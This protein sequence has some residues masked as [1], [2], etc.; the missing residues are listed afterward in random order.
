MSYWVTIMEEK[1]QTSPEPSSKFNSLKIKDDNY[2]TKIEALNVFATI[3]VKDYLEIAKRIK[4]NNDLQRKRVGSSS[5]VYGLLKEDLRNGCLIPSIVLALDNDNKEEFV[6]KGVEYNVIEN[7][8]KTYANELK[9]LDGL[10]RTNILLDLE[11]DLSVSNGKSPEQIASDKILLEAFYGRELRVEIYL[12]VSRFGILYRMLTLNTGQTPMTLRHQIEIL[13]SDYYDKENGGVTLIRDAFESNKPLKLG[14]YRFSD[15]VEGVTSF[16]D[17][18]ELPLDRYDLL[19]YIKSVKKLSSEDNKV[20]IFNA[21]KN[22]YNQLLQSIIEK[23][24]NW[25]FDYDAL[26]E[27][28]LE[29]FPVL[30]TSDDNS[31]KSRVSPFGKTAQEIFIKSQVYT[32]LG[33]A[34]SNLKNKGTIK[35]LDDLDQEFS[36]IKFE[37]APKDAFDILVVRMEQIRKD[38]KKIG[39]S[40]RTFFKHFFNSLLNKNDDD[41]YLM[42]EKAID[43]A[44][45]KTN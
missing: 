32:G 20:D 16:I 21:F 34:L 13:Y 38:S 30:S 23:S 40:Q 10:Q 44:F 7:G 2:D 14:Q 33:A 35:Q 19:D 11:N 41:S 39:E 9:I 29:Y 24:D 15:I 37:T 8:I 43:S 22:T 36:N 5:T 27:E 42:F 31:K 28:N 3:N 1:A 17:G 4:S 26:T 25:Q 6:K 18:S 12:N 45:R